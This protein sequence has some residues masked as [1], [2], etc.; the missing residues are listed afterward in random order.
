MTSFA[1]ILAFTLA[2]TALGAQ[3]PLDEPGN[4]PQFE[5]SVEVSEALLDVLVTDADGHV[6]LGLEPSDFEVREGGEPVEVFAASFYS[7]RRFL[8]RER[9]ERLQVDPKGVP[10]ARLFV[11]LFHDQIALAG[12][13]PGL[14]A[15]QLR[16]GRDAAA[17][18]RDLDPGDLVA[19]ASYGSRLRLQLDFSADRR[20]LERAID[21]ASRD[22]RPPKR[23]PSRQPAQA[24]APSLLAHLPD[25]TELRDA[26]ASIEGAIA[27]LADALATIPG[28]KNLILFTIGFGELDEVG[29]FRPNDRRYRPMMEAM[30]SANVAAYV[31]DLVDPAMTHA[32]E[33]AMSR[34]ATDTGG[35]VFFDRSEF[36]SP[37]VSI[38]ESTTGYYLVAIRSRHPAGSSGYASVEVT[39]R[40]PEFRVTAR[41]GY[42]YGA[43]D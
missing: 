17:W 19:V 7:N 34:L 36:R 20:E 24:E 33:G 35:R 2:A 37:L 10:D 9:A 29:R 38:A 16:A 39:V 27:V 1:P 13:V 18:V 23:W 12:D 26:S 43:S 3:T 32:L 8:E 4:R 22:A 31:I 11:L 15:R 21:R 6:I 30:N 14:L 40:N 5:G 28:R 41:N 42:R 25:D